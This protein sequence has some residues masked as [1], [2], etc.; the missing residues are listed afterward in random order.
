MAYNGTSGGI[1][2]VK[3]LWLQAT[4]SSNN[5]HVLT[6]TINKIKTKAGIDWTSVQ[7]S[8]LDKPLYSALAV[9]LYFT[10]WNR[11]QTTVAAQARE[12][13]QYYHGGQ[14]ADAYYETQVQELES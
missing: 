1:W 11:W 10:I 12:W 2:Q 13:N 5:A 3:V 7:Y 6:N 14:E 4:Q 8:D 9:G